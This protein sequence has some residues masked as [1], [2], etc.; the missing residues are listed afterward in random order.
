[1]ARKR[2]RPS[3]Y[4]FDSS[5]RRIL[6][7]KQPACQNPNC[8]NRAPNYKPMLTIH[9]RHIQVHEAIAY[10]IDPE[11]IR[12]E[13]NGL[14]LCDACHKRLHRAETTERPRE[15]IFSELSHLFHAVYE[16]TTQETATAT[17]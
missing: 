14:V 12:H 7:E 1:M 5:T 6:L 9:H 3:R 8:P 4:E 13:E 11:L 2:K 15:A 16:I 17:R 10:D